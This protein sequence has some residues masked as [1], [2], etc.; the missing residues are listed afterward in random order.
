MAKGA[1]RVK[2]FRLN[3]QVCFCISKLK[4]LRESEVPP[5]QP[6]SEADIVEAAVVA[7]FNRVTGEAGAGQDVIRTAA[8]KCNTKLGPLP[9]NW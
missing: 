5:W 6:V 2:S 8:A 3:D 4:E 7:Y 9:D 1:K